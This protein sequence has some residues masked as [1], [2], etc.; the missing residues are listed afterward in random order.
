M[1]VVMVEVA[2]WASWIR[3]IRGVAYRFGYT[4]KTGDSQVSIEDKS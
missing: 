2:F 3:F 1:L 4:S